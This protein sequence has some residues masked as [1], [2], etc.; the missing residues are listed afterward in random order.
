LPNTY[1][2]EI[3]KRGTHDE[4]PD[5]KQEQRERLDEQDPVYLLLP[6]FPGLLSANAW[7]PGRYRDAQP[8]KKDPGEPSFT[9]S[10]PETQQ[11]L[12]QPV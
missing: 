2:K 6:L 10:R 5:R 7:F 3:F 1:E 11:G 9:S 12:Y 8:G 4:K